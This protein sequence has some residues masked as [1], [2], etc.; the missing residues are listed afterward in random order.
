MTGA[1]TTAADAALRDLTAAP[2]WAAKGAAHADPIAA[3]LQCDAAVLAIITGIDGASYRPLGEIMT[4]CGDRRTGSLSS[5]CI[6]NDLATHAARALTD[7]PLRV[8]YG[9]GSP[10]PD[11]ALPCGGGLEITLVPRPDRAL[12]RRVLAARA[13]RLPMALCIGSDLVLGEC[14]YGETGPIADGLRIALIPEPRFLIFGNGPEAVI[15]ADLIRAAH[16]PH[17]LLSPD[18][19]TLQQGRASG[20]ETQLL[21]WRMWPDDL[22]IDARTAIVLFFHDHDWE[23]VILAHALE[24][25][26][27]YIGA[28]GSMRA[29]DAR[30]V[31]L[32][33]SGVMAG[34]ARVRGPIGLIRSVKDPR[35]L[36]VSV[37]AE[38]LEQAR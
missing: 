11:L 24:S 17:L 37:L 30:L 29:R 36:A 18:A 14:A 35:I 21:Q 1:K 3:A 28:Q 26:A 7:G 15:F 4:F 12:L 23:P 31:A 22:G 20:C 27:F 13:A 2:A 38:I 16:Y 32:R 10:W 25:P 8:R 19:E 6:E 9:A 34:L 5:G 33:Q